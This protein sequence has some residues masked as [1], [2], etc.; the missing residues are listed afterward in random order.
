MWLD[1]KLV[2]HFLLIKYFWLIFCWRV[3]YSYIICAIMELHTWT[4]TGRQSSSYKQLTS[5]HT[6]TSRNLLLQSTTEAVIIFTHSQTDSF[7]NG[8]GKGGNKR[9]KQSGRMS[10]N[11]SENARKQQKLNIMHFP[12]RCKKIINK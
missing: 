10:L 3:H 7:L 5:P 1:T 2:V 12:L 9:E 8:V 11:V 4:A 6:H